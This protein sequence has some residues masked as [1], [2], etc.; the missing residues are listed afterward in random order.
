M[1]LT[2]EF[3]KKPVVL[4]L[5]IL[6]SWSGYAQIEILP[7]TTRSC[8]VDSLILDAGAGFNTYFWNTGAITQQIWVDTTGLYSV[9]VIGDTVDITDT[10]YVIILDVKIA[11]NDTTIFCG[12]TIILS[13]TS[14]AFDYIWSP[15][16]EFSDSI[17]VYP[18]DT[19]MFYTVISDTVLS[20]NYCL[21]S[22]LVTVDPIIFIDTIFQFRMGCK[23]SS[24]ARVEFAVFGGYPPYDIDCFNIDKDPPVHEGLVGTSSPIIV[25][26]KD[27]NKLLTVSD[28]IG[29]R[30][31]Q[32]FEVDAYPL[33][34]I[35]LYS[36]PEDSTTI[37]LQNPIV[38][39]SFENISY[40]STMADTFELQRFAWDFGDSTKLSILFSPTHAYAKTGD[41]DVVF[42]YTTLYGCPG[43]DTLTIT[44]EPVDLRITTVLTPNG[45][46]ANDLFEVFE[47]T[48]EQGGGNGGGFKSTYSTEEPIDLSLYYLS[49]TLIVFNRWGEK[50][51]EVDNYKNDWDGDGLVD[52]V[53][54]YILKCDGQYD[55]KVYKGSVTIFNSQ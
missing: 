50:V 39:F 1:S 43:A 55:D 18:R 46:G 53:Y 44:V 31:V 8:Q 35:K 23:D 32:D 14:S 37:Y 30:A 42:D 27:G 48:G 33:P 12:D 24:A 34:E 2:L 6:V 41:F 20:S 11:Q 52:G 16:T 47:N 28:T 29:C 5:L 22:V 9:H 3:N 17:L 4:F 51:F 10:T 54:F 45:D 25:K 19:T 49:N 21:D 36:D 40:D 15:V 13:G 26:L 38:T 7:D